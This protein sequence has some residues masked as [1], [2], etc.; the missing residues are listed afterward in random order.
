MVIKQITSLT[1]ILWAQY[2]LVVSLQFAI[3]LSC[4]GSLEEL[5]IGKVLIALV[6]SK[7]VATHILMNYY[8]YCNATINFAIG[9]VTIFCMFI[10]MLVMM[11]KE[12]TLTKS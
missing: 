7:Y 11:A 10:C 12:Y 3:V 5:V 4:R 8:Y 2:L 1:I 9:A 6:V